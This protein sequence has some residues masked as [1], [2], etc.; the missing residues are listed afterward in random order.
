MESIM[1]WCSRIIVLISSIESVNLS[2]KRTYPAD[3]FER[4]LLDRRL[5]LGLAGIFSPQLVILLSISIE[6]H[7]FIARLTKPPQML[8]HT[9]GTCRYML[10]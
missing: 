10:V 4:K 9:V 5:D 1:P 6:K 8:Y 7:Q 2:E 3:F